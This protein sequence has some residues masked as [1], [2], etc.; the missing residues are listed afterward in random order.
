M[1]TG[2][3]P[4]PEVF[5]TRDGLEIPLSPPPTEDDRVTAADGPTLDDARIRR[6]GRDVALARRLT[7]LGGRDIDGADV[8][9]LAPDEDAAIAAAW[10]VAAGAH[11]VLAIDLRSP[12]EHE[13]SLQAFER[14]WAADEPG[15]PPSRAAIRFIRDDPTTAE[16]PEASAEVI[17]GRGLLSRVAN[18]PGTM[19]RHARWLRPGGVMVHEYRPFHAADSP[20]VGPSLRM[21]WGHVRLDPEDLIRLLEE[22]HREAA[23]D[24]LERLA[25][26]PSRATQ[27]QVRDAVTAAGLAIDAWLPWVSTEDVLRLTPEILSQCRRRFPGMHADDLVGRIVRFTAHRP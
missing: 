7:A 3:P 15:P 12:E 8:V 25:T 6:I 19:A 26:H 10:C 2:V 17:L 14:V 5:R 20:V 4:A 23:A 9:L 27:S 1:S 18:L 16:L 11:A 13:R 21:P 24:V 22:H